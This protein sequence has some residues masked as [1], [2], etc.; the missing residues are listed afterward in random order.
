MKEA[1]F[2]SVK[3]ALTQ[4]MVEERPNVINSIRN[5]L[6][7][8]AQAHLNT[9]LENYA[10]E[11]G[12]FENLAFRNLGTTAAVRNAM[13]IPTAK[14]HSKDVNFDKAS[15]QDKQLYIQD[16]W[17]SVRGILLNQETK[18]INARS[19]LDAAEKTEE[20]RKAGDKLDVM[21]PQGVIAG[22]VQ[23]ERARRGG[24]IFPP[25]P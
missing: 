18:R 13:S 16:H 9:A 6:P 21:G 2:D 7:G 19:D 23:R 17:T 4:Y 12:E 5:R 11:D 1:E 10:K 8:A 22:H 15:A 20:I 25:G 3:G 14:D 24:F